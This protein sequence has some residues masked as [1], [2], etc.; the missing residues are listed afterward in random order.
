MKRLISALLASAMLLSLTACT[1]KKTD[2]EA[3][4]APAEE[5]AAACISRLEP[6]TPLFADA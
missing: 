5:Q 3:T 6:P 4:A 2:T 1:S